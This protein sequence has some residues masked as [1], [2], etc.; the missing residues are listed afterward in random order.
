MSTGQSIS[1]PNTPAQRLVLQEL[2]SHRLFPGYCE[3]MLATGLK[4]YKAVDWVLD[5]L[6]RR[7][8]VRRDDHGDYELTDNGRAALQVRPC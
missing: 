3:L 7:G 1:A 8:L 5:A 6:E 4:S 2:N